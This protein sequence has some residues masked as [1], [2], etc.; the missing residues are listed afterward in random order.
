[1]KSCTVCINTYQRPK[2]LTA[3]LE[4]LG[5]Q[6][7]PADVGLE[8]VV[9][10][11][12]WTGSAADVVDHA[13]ERLTIDINYF[14]E[15]KKNISLARNKAVAEATGEYLL[16][17]DDDEQADPYWIENMLS[18]MERFGGDAVFGRVVPN[19][20]DDA[21]QWLR[22]N[23]LYNR[24]CRPTG[25]RVRTGRTSNALVK[26]SLLKD[27][28]L[29]FDPDYGATGGEDSDL[30]ER[31]AAE[32]AHMVSC[33]EGLVTEYVPKE[34]T[35]V[36]WLTQRAKRTG[37][38][39]ALRR[40]RRPNTSYGSTLMLMSKALVGVSLAKA[41]MLVSARDQARWLNWTV[42]SASYQGHLLGSLGRTIDGY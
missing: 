27:R 5:K 10:D 4:S 23:E 18:T 7:L 35:T 11:N 38:L 9:V 31:L 6:V 34:R 17:M 21:P 28:D 29:I 40:M 32:G 33:F 20:H 25:T 41:M 42:R 14:C 8:I 26:A 3:T 24:P 13:R 36:A 22:K 39:Y 30:F 1:M 15:P 37:M 16:F 2:L 19:F 12:D